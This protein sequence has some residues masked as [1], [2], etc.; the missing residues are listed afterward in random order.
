MRVLVRFIPLF[1]IAL[2]A[3]AEDSVF[4]AG[5]AKVDIT[6]ESGM[7]QPITDMSQPLTPHDRLFARVLVLKDAKTSIAIVATDSLVFASPVVAE[8]AKRR[9]GVKHILQS[10][11]HTHAGTMPRGLLIGGPDKKPDWTRGSKAPDALL[12][13]RGLSSDP[14]YAKTEQQI[15]AAIGDERTH[16]T[17]E[18]LTVL[19]QVERVMPVQKKHKL[20]S[21]ESHPANS[22]VNVDGVVFGVTA[23]AP[24]LGSNA[25]ITVTA[26]TAALGPL[27]FD[28]Y[29]A[30]TKHAV[31]GYVRSLGPVLD[32]K[33]TRLNSSHR[34]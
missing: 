21:R 25:A 9:F 14:W 1:F 15:I 2:F 34:T 19:P 4:E 5:T 28:P 30:A 6:P 18:S 24:M 10:S 29:Y 7:A 31:A 13:W 26:S 12:D 20:V 33:S 3:R 23:L 22:T 27:P 11:T 16:H 32:R 8:E 17:L